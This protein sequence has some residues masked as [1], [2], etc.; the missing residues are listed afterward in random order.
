[1]PIPNG[2]RKRISDKAYAHAYVD[3][4]LNVSIASQ[5]KALRDQRGLTQEQLAELAGMKQARICVVEN[6]NYS[7]WT[8]NT[9][10]KLAEAFDVTLRVSF[11]T[12][13]STLNGMRDFS[14]ESLERISRADEIELDLIIER[15]HPA[16]KAVFAQAPTV[17]AIKS[18]ALLTEIGYKPQ[19][20]AYHPVG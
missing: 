11:E 20:L 14:R 9:L 5:I 12:F 6:V 8:I 15:Q 1:M 2:L 7:S 13:G 19:S 17:T 4:Y 10:R 16:G 3:E 18:Q